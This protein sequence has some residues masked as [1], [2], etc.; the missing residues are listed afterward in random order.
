M[1][2]SL[3]VLLLVGFGAKRASEWARLPGIVGMVLAGMVLGPY[4]ADVLHGDLLDIS[5]DLRA[6]ALIL[7]LL[8]A[9]LGLDRDTLNQVGG[10]SLRLG[11]I[12]CVV[13]GF[14]VMGLAHVIWQL[15]WLE[16][17]MLGFILA[18]V[19][20]AVV[21]PAMLR[22]RQAGLGW[23]KQVPTM[24][25]AGA[26]LDDVIAITVFSAFLGASVAGYGVWSGLA[27]LP[28]QVFL[29]ILGGIVLGL[30]L[31]WAY[32]QRLFD[33]RNTEKLVLLVSTTMIYYGLGD[34]AGWASLLGVMA[35]G[36]LLLEYRPD[37]ARQFA[38]KLNRTWVFAEII[39]FV[40]VG[41]A[42][43]VGVAWQ[44][45]LWGLVIIFLGLTARTVGVWAATWGT[46]L[47]RSERMFCAVAYWPKATVQA[48][49][50]GIPLAAGIESGERI[51]ATAVLA[52]IVSA[53]LGSFAIEWSSRRLLTAPRRE[54]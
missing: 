54:G 1:L 15:P 44:A 3:A 12:P 50:G 29:G 38:R 41:A 37:T 43:N 47:N 36:L 22:L 51:L 35:V 42:V 18:A 52:I 32:Q 26:S 8:R 45:G 40:L 6:M 23:D 14:A 31:L 19:S 13:E 20:P 39:L 4:G 2:Q 27:M 5:A 17:G 7:I 24:V 16:A 49:V 9:G 10:A 46:A 48:A 25:L 21:V 33:V 11:I 30:L 28:V 34:Q 53:P